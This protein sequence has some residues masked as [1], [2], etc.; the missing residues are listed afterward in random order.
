M[1]R[2]APMDVRD[3]GQRK[4]HSTAA[5]RTGWLR[6][7]VAAKQCGMVRSR[8]HTLDGPGTWRRAFE[9]KAPVDVAGVKRDRQLWK[10]LHGERR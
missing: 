3:P 8:A 5:R 6:A 1:G 10:Q 4:G 2:H 7:A 9:G